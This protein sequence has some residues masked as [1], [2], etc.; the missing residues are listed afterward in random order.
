MATGLAAAE[1]NSLLDTML[2]TD[3]TFIQLHTADPGAAGTA[4]VAGNA[5][6]KDISAS[7]A[8]ASGG[9]KSTDVDISWTD[10]EVDTTETYSHFSLWTL[11]TG[12]TFGLSGTVSAAE[13]DATGETFTIPAGSGTVSFGIAS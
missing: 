9:S 6:R 10:G 13:V 3:Y 11:G 7:W 5:T 8:A 12:G 2:D 1:A 4:N